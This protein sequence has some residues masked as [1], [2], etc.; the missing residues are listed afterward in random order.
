VPIESDLQVTSST[1][2]EKRKTI[3]LL[4]GLVLV[5]LGALLARSGVSAMNPAALSLI[6]VFGLSNVFLVWIP[7]RMM[8][9]PRFELIV[10]SVDI[11]V[12][13]L[14]TLLASAWAGVLAISCLLMML[15]VALGHYRTHVVTG[16]LG[17]T[18]FH[19]WYVVSSYSIS[20]LGYVAFEVIFLCSIALYY[21]YLLK[22]IQWTRRRREAERTERRE[23][24]TLLKI[25]EAIASSL[26]VR[27]VTNAIVTYINTV[28]P[29]VRCSLLLVSDS[30]KRCHVIASHDDPD[31]YMLEL[32]LG[33]YPEVRRAIMTREP[34]IISDVSQDPVMAEV[35][36]LLS[37]LDF[38]SIMVLPLTF[39]EDVLGTLLLKTARAGMDFSQPEI[40]FCLAVARASANA[41]KNAMLHREAQEESARHRRTAEKLGSILDHSPDLILTTDMEGCI[42]ELNRS[43]E[44]L[45]RCTKADLLQKPFSTLFV[46]GEDL[47]FVRQVLSSGVVSNRSCQLRRKDGGELSMELSLSVLTSED[48]DAYGTVWVGRDVTALKAAQ[49]QLLQAEKLSSIGSVIA[50]VVH[51]L[52]NPLSSV[53]GFSQLLMTNCSDSSIMR[54]LEA[55]NESGVRCHKIVKNLLSFARGHKPERKYLG[56]NGIMEKTLDLKEYQ[57]RVNDIEVV[58][59]LDDELPRTMLDFHQMQQVFL[60]IINNAEQA[61]AGVR[62]RRRLTV[63]TRYDGEGIRLEI[64]DNGEGIDRSTMRRVF[65]PFFTTKPEGQG[66]GLG[67]SVSYGIVREHG[68]CIFADS[69]KGEGATFVIVLP[70]CMERE[71][72]GEERIG[73][74]VED[75]VAETDGKKR[76]LIVDDEPTILDLLIMILEDMGHLVDTAANGEEACRKVLANQYDLVITDVK[77]PRMSGIDLYRTLLSERP[78]MIGNVVFISGDLMN[79]ETARFLSEVNARTLAKPLEIPELVQVVEEALA[80][81][82]E[83]SPA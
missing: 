74:P 37:D 19:T 42:T 47:D 53:I 43:G 31:V 54:Q 66:T 16:A 49:M 6:L 22:D 5:A 36:S 80:A 24:H 13:A 20:S 58:R 23:L 55:I 30:A 57:L 45:L 52:N 3:V 28:V 79:E 75:R 50:G 29:S 39:G 10:G 2:R 82:A 46:P 27:H 44:R 4:R 41:L 14:G 60:N 11:L 12:V 72:I 73:N 65:D 56:V 77:M 83:G 18:A 63:R 69:R 76:I 78:G 35:Q 33:K 1:N 48:G 67:L 9:S 38:Q 81:S 34:V 61:M 40:E 17:V 26:D 32:D 59:D 51:E 70:V 25:L 68:G 64:A 71:E 8:R 62:S 7:L 21:S 15:V